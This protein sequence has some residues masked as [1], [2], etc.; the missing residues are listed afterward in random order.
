MW[1]LCLSPSL[2]LLQLLTAPQLGRAAILSVGVACCTLLA[3]PQ[4]QQLAV[5]L[6]D[7]FVSRGKHKVKSSSVC[8][9]R[10]DFLSPNVSLL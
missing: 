3:D 1:V 5:R 7:S 10:V 8:W 6:L 2:S 9:S 4:Q